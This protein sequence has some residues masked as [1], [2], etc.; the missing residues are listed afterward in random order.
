MVSFIGLYQ[1]VLFQK[2]SEGEVW[3]FLFSLPEP[4]PV[5]LNLDMQKAQNA[6]AERSNSSSPHRLAL[7]SSLV[8]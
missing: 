7:E 1:L 4:Q 5:S 3:R 8:L 6:L 2:G